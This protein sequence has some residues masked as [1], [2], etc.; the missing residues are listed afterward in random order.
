M[1]LSELMAATS[2]IDGIF[3][4]AAVTSP[5]QFEGDLFTG[6]DVNVRGT[7]NVLKAVSANH[8]KRIVLVSSSSVYGNI[9]KAGSEDMQIPGHENMYS[10]TK[11]FEEHL[12]KYFTKRGKW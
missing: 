5:P 11:L 9:S 10:M 7:L 6:F 1:D 8:V 2:D 4:L 3:H 12:G